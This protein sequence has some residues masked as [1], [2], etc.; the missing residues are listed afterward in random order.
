M[1]AFLFLKMSTNDM[2]LPI[3]GFS[4]YP[5]IRREAHMLALDEQF[6]LAFHMVLAVST[7]FKITHIFDGEDLSCGSRSYTV[8]TT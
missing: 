4:L 5:L 3:S 7:K 1:V 2:F 8:N 6:Y